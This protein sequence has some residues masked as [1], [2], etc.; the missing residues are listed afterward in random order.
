MVTRI[1]ALL[2]PLLIWRQIILLY[3]LMLGLEGPA[4]LL[5]ASRYKRPRVERLLALAPVAVFCALLAVARALADTYAYWVGYT[6]WEEATYPPGSWPAMLAQTARDA[7]PSA[8]GVTPLG[9]GLAVLTAALLIGGWALVIRW[10]APPPPRPKAAP[11]VPAAPTIPATDVAGTLEITIAPIPPVRA[12]SS[13]P[14][15]PAQESG[16]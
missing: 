13:L 16:T 7:A 11:A 8:H 3:A 15:E 5:A 6:A 9:I 14:D 2:L 4:L 12:Q 1:E 10:Q